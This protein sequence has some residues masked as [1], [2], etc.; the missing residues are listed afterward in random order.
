M[1]LGTTLDHRG[2]MLKVSVLY[3]YTE[4][5]KFD[6]E[7]F[8]RQHLPL[9]DKAWGAALIKKEIDAG[10][11]GPGP[12]THPTY[13]AVAHLYFDSIESFQAALGP[14]HK[15][16]EKDARNFTDIK[17]TIQVSKVVFG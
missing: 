13:V 11:S 4:G 5:G 9:V 15:E 17:P 2:D 3:P 6:M 8:L 14:Q 16:L 10:L 1:A 7:Y 12:G